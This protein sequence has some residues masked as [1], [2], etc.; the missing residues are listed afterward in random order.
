LQV[1]QLVLCTF[2]ER[3]W[4]LAEYLADVPA[5]FIADV[6]V[7]AAQTLDSQ[8]GAKYVMMMPCAWPSL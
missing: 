7:P 6:L 8:K 1:Q 5:S 4:R 3:D 2:L